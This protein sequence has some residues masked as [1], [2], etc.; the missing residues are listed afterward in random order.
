MYLKRKIDDYLKNWKTSD[1]KFPLIVKGARQIGKTAS[2]LNFAKGNY[3]N[4]VYVN[5]VTDEVFRTITKDGY[6]AQAI[7]KNI[8]Y[9][10]TRR[11]CDL[12]LQSGQSR[13]G[14]GLESAVW[15]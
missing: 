6:S 13:K 1:E 4:V 7:I 3:K 9:I 10:D 11:H 14:I 5:F 15:P 12:L 2:I 8:S